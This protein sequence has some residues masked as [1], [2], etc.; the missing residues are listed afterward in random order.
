M[1]PLHTDF[2]EVGVA[3]NNPSSISVIYLAFIAFAAWPIR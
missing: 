3:D 2:L 1:P